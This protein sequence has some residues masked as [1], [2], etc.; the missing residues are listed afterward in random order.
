METNRKSLD[1]DL[2]YDGAILIWNTGLP[3]LNETYKM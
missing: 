2:I 1:P 3:F